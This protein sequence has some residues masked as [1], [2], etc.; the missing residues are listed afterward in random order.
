MVD[1][2]LSVLK[3]DVLRKNLSV[4]KNILLIGKLLKKSII[5]ALQHFFDEFINN[6]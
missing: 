1:L 6:K 4:L 2:L 3:E 5:L